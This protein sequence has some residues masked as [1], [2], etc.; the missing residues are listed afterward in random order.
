MPPRST[1]KTPPGPGS[2]R[3]LRGRATAAAENA[4]AQAVPEEPKVKMEEIAGSEMEQKASAE[5]KVALETVLTSVKSKPYPIFFFR[6][7]LYCTMT[8]WDWF[9][10]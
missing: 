10:L 1:K 9:C 4:Q 8:F 3:A 7:M 6:F 5:D 2:K